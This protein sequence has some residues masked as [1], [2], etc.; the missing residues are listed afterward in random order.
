MRIAV[1]VLAAS[2]FEAAALHSAGAQTTRPFEALEASRREG[3][4]RE[5]RAKRDEAEQ[6]RL[7]KEREAQQ[8]KEAA[9]NKANE[10]PAA[11][12]RKRP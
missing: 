10:G 9:S 6:R 4:E 7:E 8:K 2:I 5:A 1:A 3:I 11:P 12:S